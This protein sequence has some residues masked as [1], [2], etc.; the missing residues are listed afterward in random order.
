MLVVAYVINEGVKNLCGQVAMLVLTVVMVLGNIT[1][2]VFQF[3]N[4]SGCPYT[5]AFM[6]LTI[7][8]TIA[9]YAIVP[10]RTREDASILTSS[11]VWTYVLYLQ[12]S[13]LSSNPDTT[14]N[15]EMQN[16]GV[17]VAKTVLG[18]FFSFVALFTISAISKKDTT[19][20]QGVA[21]AANEPLITKE[22]DGLAPVAPVQEVSAEQQH[23]Y[24]ISPATI[25]F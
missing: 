8:L 1:W 23:V 4:F 16:Y 15:S 12:W 20:E 18:V 6:I 10:L 7:V 3:L 14:C 25:Y 9:T 5:V 11:L 19:E 2:T 17:G 24:P 13:A 21:L 22:D